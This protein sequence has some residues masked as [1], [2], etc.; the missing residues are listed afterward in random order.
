MRISANVVSLT[1]QRFMGQTQRSV[2]KALQQMASGSRFAD[3]GADPAGFAIAENMRSQ[4]QGYKSAKMNAENA[5]SFVQIAE[6]A[7]N[8][9]NN[10]LIRMRELA[11]QA[12]SD[13]YSDTE[14]GYLNDEFNQINAES[15][16]IARTTKF[17]SQSLLDGASKDYE[18]QV[19]VNKSQNDIVRYTS[20]TNTTAGELGTEGLTIESKGD[21]RD[22]LEEIDVALTRINGA[23]AKMGAIQN[24]MD[25]V[26]NHIDSQISGLSEA[27]SRMADA[28]LAEAVMTARRGQ[29]LQQYQA[30][31]LGMALESEQAQ[32]RLI[33]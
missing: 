24:R 13:T 2:E 11:V 1:S 31:A 6:G 30:A 23:R 19:G 33:A 17:G 4:I 15:D 20:D 7:L 29:M 22:S 25:N 16:R 21:A 26:V 28:D 5:T 32:L 12:A 10:I 8:E 27:H 18:F 3:T 14:R 9:Q